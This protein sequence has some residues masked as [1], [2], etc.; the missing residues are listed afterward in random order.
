MARSSIVS[1]ALVALLGSAV[2][3]YAAESETFTGTAA[4]PGTH[5]RPQLL[6]DGRRHEL[7]ASDKADPSMAETLAKFSKGDTGTYAV[8]GTRDTANSAD[9]LLNDTITMAARQ[10]PSTVASARP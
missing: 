10:L 7:T 5:K 1:T 9:G 8:K 2:V 6:V 4:S 3:G